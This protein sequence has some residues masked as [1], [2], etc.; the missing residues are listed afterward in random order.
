[1]LTSKCHDEKF[2][3]YF[4]DITYSLGTAGLKARQQAIAA[5]LKYNPARQ[6]NSLKV[7]LWT[8]VGLRQD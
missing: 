6:S 7:V 8:L 3:D 4:T 2:G 5:T 1:M